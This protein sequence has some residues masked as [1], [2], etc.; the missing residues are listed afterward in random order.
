NSYFSPL[1]SV[2]CITFAIVSSFPVSSCATNPSN[3]VVTQSTSYPNSSATASNT[4][5]SN[6]VN[7][8]SSSILLGKLCPVAPALIT[9]FS[10]VS[11]LSASASDVVE[12]LLQADNAINRLII[13]KTN[14]IF[15]FILLSPL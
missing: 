5:T 7:S 14:I 11:S 15:L 10:S 13:D 12:S 6:P 8:P 4:S 9:F 1:S 3:A 2:I